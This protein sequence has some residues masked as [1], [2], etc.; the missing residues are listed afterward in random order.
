MFVDIYCFTS[1]AATQQD[2]SDY[3]FKSE[4]N[5]GGTS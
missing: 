3:K 2:T 5:L 1:D 4:P